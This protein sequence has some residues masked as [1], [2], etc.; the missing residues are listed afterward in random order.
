MALP[1]DFLEEVETELGAARRGLTR[2]RARTAA[3]E[4]LHSLVLDLT[5]DLG[6]PI[7]VFDLIRSAKT[8][9]ERDRRLA[10]A[11]ELRTDTSTPPEAASR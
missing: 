4:E 10:L 7:S 1:R 3:L 6:R 8:Q 9:R 2:G 5:H 11:R